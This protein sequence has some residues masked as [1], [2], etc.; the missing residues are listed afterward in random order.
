M[1]MKRAGDV[2][3]FRFPNSNF[4]KSKSRP[5]ILLKKLPYGFDDW[6]ICMVTT[7]LDLCIDGFDEV[8][9]TESD[10]FTQSGL[11]STSG[12]RITRLAVVEGQI[13][14]GKIGEISSQRLNRIKQNLSTWFN[15]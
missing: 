2:V 14:V 9:K 11:L 13:L 15:E 12:I 3:V 4:S 7:Q 5:A 8:I 10:D 1:E 6:L